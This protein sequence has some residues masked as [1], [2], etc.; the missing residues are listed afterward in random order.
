MKDLSEIE[1][2]KLREPNKIRENTVSGPRKEVVFKIYPNKRRTKEP[3]PRSEYER[4]QPAAKSGYLVP[5]Q[6]FFGKRGFRNL[7]PH[8]NAWY[9]W[10]A[11]WNF[12]TIAHGGYLVEPPN[13]FDGNGKPHLK[14]RSEIPTLSPLREFA[15]QLHNKGER[16][17]GLYAGWPARFKPEKN[18]GDYCFIQ[19]EPAVFRLGNASAFPWGYALKCLEDGFEEH[20]FDLVLKKG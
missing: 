8:S 18:S 7:Y 15:R 1:V 13:D 11:G 19:E 17:C 4:G 5:A 16:W 9:F 2:P 12:K 3:K 10:G 20:V 14:V 6:R